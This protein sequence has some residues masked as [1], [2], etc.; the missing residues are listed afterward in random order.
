MRALKWHYLKNPVASVGGAEH[1]I[2]FL[3]RPPYDYSV[4]ASGIPLAIEA[5]SMRGKQSFPFALIRDHQVKGMEAAQNAGALAYILVSFRSSKPS[6][7]ETYAIPFTTFQSLQLE[8]P[9]KSIPANLFLPTTK[10]FICLARR[11]VYGEEGDGELIWDLRPLVEGHH[12]ANWLDCIVRS[13]N[14]K[15]YWEQPGPTESNQ[16][17]E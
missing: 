3:Q 1:N 10:D 2:K 17:E 11:H 4:V 16:A 13:H 5:K 9:R 12:I 8:L 7:R 15:C 14:L 6:E